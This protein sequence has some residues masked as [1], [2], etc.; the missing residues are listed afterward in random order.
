[1]TKEDKTFIDKWSSFLSELLVIPKIPIKYKNID[2][3]GRFYVEQDNPKATCIIIKNN[4]SN[5][6]LDYLRVLTH[7][8]MHYFQCFCIAFKKDMEKEIGSKKIKLYE[9]ELKD[10]KPYGYKGY[11]NQFIEVEAVAFTLMVFLYFDIEIK[12]DYNV[13]DRSSVINE[14]NNKLYDFSKEEIIECLESIK[15][16]YNNIKIILKNYIREEGVN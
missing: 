13:Y 7:E 5:N 2:V 11:Q 10:Y 15:L 1:M 3:L 14:L 9:K 6:L 12:E 8:Y 16:N 4:F